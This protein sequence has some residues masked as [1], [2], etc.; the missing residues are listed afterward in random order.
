MEHVAS[1]YPFP[2]T[3][4]GPGEAER[5][6]LEKGEKTPRGFEARE[7]GINCSYA[8]YTDKYDVFGEKGQKKALKGEGKIAEEA[9]KEVLSV[10]RDIPIRDILTLPYVQVFM[11]EPEI[12]VN[13][14]L[15][16]DTPLIIPKGQQPLEELVRK[17]NMELFRKIRGKLLEEH[18]GKVAVIA[19]GEYIIGRTSDEAIRR[20]REKFPNDKPKIIWKIK[21][22][23]KR[24]R[25]PRV[26]GIRVRHRK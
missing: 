20:A 3:W 8:L 11:S 2:G 22:E 6:T 16:H 7:R 1:Q 15:S 9:R 24:P 18:S 13:E 25:V 17:K 26:G 5:G 19:N 10:T 4:G 12:D 14:I 23:E 21:E